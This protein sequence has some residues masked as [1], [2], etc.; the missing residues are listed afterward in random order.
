M[1]T[2]A[3]RMY[4]WVLS[5]ELADSL[6]LLDVSMSPLAAFTV[7]VWVGESVGC[8]VGGLTGETETETLVGVRVGE[9]VGWGV[10]VGAVE[11]LAVGKAVGAWVG[12]RDGAS[13][14]GNDG[15][16]PQATE[17]QV[18]LQI[19]DNPRP[20]RQLLAGMIPCVA[21]NVQKCK[22]PVANVHVL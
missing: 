21:S 9:R 17:G 15:C 3:P 10:C 2:V 12:R 22:K 8:V 7:G 20:C 18:I 11:V 5:S 14:G 6:P 4:F 13:D 19:H 1:A 16:C